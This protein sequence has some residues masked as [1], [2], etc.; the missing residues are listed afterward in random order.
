M[1]YQKP[2]SNGSTKSIKGD[3]NDRQ[4]KRHLVSGGFYCGMG[5]IGFIYNMDFNRNMKKKNKF[6][7][8][9]TNSLKQVVYMAIWNEEVPKKCKKVKCYEN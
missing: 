3:R 9:A 1:V 8:K 2:Q 4:T 7:R 6:K 5:D